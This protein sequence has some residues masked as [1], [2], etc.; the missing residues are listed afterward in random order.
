MEKVKY[1][2]SAETNELL[3]IINEVQTALD[4]YLRFNAD[5]WHEDSA[6]HEAALEWCSKV[7]EHM[8]EDLKNVIVESFESSKTS[9]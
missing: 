3:N 7:H 4:K 2:V 1:T 8:Y 5:Y 9:I 6:T